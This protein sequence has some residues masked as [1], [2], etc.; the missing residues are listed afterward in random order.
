MKLAENKKIYHDYEI[1][2]TLEAGLVLSGPEV[3]SAKLGQID[4]KGAYVEIDQNMESWL[5]NSYIAPYKPAKTSQKNYK[6]H[7]P[8]KLL[9]KKKELRSLLGKQKEKGTSIVPLEIFLKKRLVKIKIGIG[10][11]KKKHDKRETIKKRDFEK[12]K[13]KIM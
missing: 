8:R 2:N 5:I 7:A 6:P 9:L 11:G 3:K 12:R 13:K 4:L 1:S 10:R